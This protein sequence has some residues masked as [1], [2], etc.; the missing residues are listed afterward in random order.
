MK[1]HYTKIDDGC[2]VTL[3]GRWA[4]LGNGDL[5]RNVTEVE[6]AVTC[7]KCRVTIASPSFVVDRLIA[8]TAVAAND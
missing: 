6:A 8:E 1:M 2:R 3:C 4:D 7:Q 5:P